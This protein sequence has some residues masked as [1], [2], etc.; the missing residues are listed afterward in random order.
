MKTSGKIKTVIVVSILIVGLSAPAPGRIIYV[1]DDATGANDGSSWANAFQYLQDGLV[2]VLPAPPVHRGDPSPGMKAQAEIRVAQG[3]YKPQEATLSNPWVRSGLQSA[4][5][6]AFRL[7][8]GVAI[9]G[10][11]AGLGASDPNERNP[12]RY[13]T[14]LSGDLNGDDA[15]V[16]HA[17]DLSSDPT[18]AENSHNVV[19]SDPVADANAVLDGCVVTGATRGGLE[20]RGGGPSISNCVFLRNAAQPYGGA[21]RSM[22]G[23]LTLTRCRFIANWAPQFGGAVDADLGGVILLTDCSFTDN[24][25]EVGGAVASER[26]DVRMRVK[27]GH[28]SRQCIADDLRVGVQ[29]QHIAPARSRQTLVVRRWKAAI[30][31]VGD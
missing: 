13:Q 29:R 6:M 25:A 1:D 23:N 18:R 14:I 21:V 26:A 8:S 20:N 31:D 15:D 16:V 24:E 19:T 2:S 9:K 30:V 22:T 3:I 12:E 7:V 10:G 5:E 28:H 4:P 11:Y 17:R 27:V